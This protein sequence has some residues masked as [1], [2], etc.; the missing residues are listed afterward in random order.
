MSYDY[1]KN[2]KYRQKRKICTKNFARKRCP[3][4]QLN[5]KLITKNNKN[6]IFAG[7]SICKSNDAHYCDTLKRNQKSTKRADMQKSRKL[8]L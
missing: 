2:E 5:F 1:K 7:D 6:P 3:P 8:V 4:N